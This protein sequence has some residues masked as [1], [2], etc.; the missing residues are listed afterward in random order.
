MTTQT[1]PLSHADSAAA[2]ST[3]VVWMRAVMPVLLCFA[4]AFAMYG[5]QLHVLADYP[6]VIAMNAGIAMMLALSLSIVNGM[7]GQFSIGH[8]GFMA[9]GGY[10][11]GMITYYGSLLLWQSTA[12]E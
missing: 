6:T 3:G 8:A 10:A 5:L 7:T 12:M 4:F 2:V 1:A 9:L 11:A